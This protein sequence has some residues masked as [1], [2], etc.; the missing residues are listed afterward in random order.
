MAFPS[1]SRSPSYSIKESREDSV[2]RSDYEAGYVNTRQ[3][4]T[5]VRR[6]WELRYPYLTEV[7]VST[8]RTFIDTTVHGGADAFDWTNPVDSVTYQ[9]RLQ[10]PPEFIA[11]FSNPGLSGTIYSADI[12]LDQV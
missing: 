8:L 1:L 7:D 10:K 11:Y 12:L 5:R 9:V 4:F 3:R 2:L 6:K